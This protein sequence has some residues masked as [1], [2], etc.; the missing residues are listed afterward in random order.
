MVLSTLAPSKNTNVP[1]RIAQLD[2]EK[3]I[4]AVAALLHERMEQLANDARACGNDRLAADIVDVKLELAN[5]VTMIVMSAQLARIR[6][7]ELG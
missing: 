3:N 2:L 7:K 4:L 1:N 6:E 5:R